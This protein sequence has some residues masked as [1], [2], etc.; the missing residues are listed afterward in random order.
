[1]GTC[2]AVLL[3]LG[4]AGN[5]SGPLAGAAVG[6]LAL[7]SF[8]WLDAS[9]WILS[10]PLFL[11]WTFLA[12]WAADRAI[13]PVRSRG[14]GPGALG[15]SGR[16][17]GPPPEREANGVAVRPVWLLVATIATGL[18]C[19]TRAAG[20]PLALALLAALL[21]GRRFR[22]VSAIAAGLAIPAVLWWIHARGGG[23]AGAYGS[24]L[25]MV[26]PYEPELGT[27]GWLD[28][29]VRA[30]G[31]LR[32][33]VWGVLPGEWWPVQE[34]STAALLGTVLAATAAGG[35]VLRIR[36][37]GVETAELFAPL[38]L[39]MILVW[40][41][42]WSGERFILPLYPLALLYAGVALQW[43]GR[44]LGAG[45]AIAVPALGFVALALPALPGW[46]GLAQDAG[47]CRRTVAVAGD[48][49]RCHTDGIREFREAAEWSRVN[50]PPGAV[51]LNRKPRIFYVLGG[52]PG[53]VFPFTQ[54]PGALLAE[55]D[56]L[57]A[58][59]LLLDHVDAVSPYYLLAVVRASPLAFCYLAGWG[60]EGG[61]VGTDLLGILPPQ[62]RR[63]GGDLSAVQRCPPG[64]RV[65][66]P[67]SVGPDG[68]RIPLLAG[69]G[70]NQPPESP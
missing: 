16:A 70:A 6:L 23:G 55:A 28:L 1:V 18:A 60:G 26:N 50:L 61:D 47:A 7:L 25:W 5:R 54:D 4:W 59:Y 53:R 10:E 42:V 30:W 9:R 20:A 32:L 15:G 52:L 12:L 24:E 39:S 2:V 31:N 48:V 46:L 69:R 17:P 63:E 22:W 13:P 49:F 33:Y 45:A 43:A 35:W 51:V 11:A 3:V 29:P 21:F 66:P 19:M 67:R 58:R 65:D 36:S 8:G 56:A 57:G 68:R 64:Y 44:G 40:P 41:E 37:H 34:G 14:A 62:E 38:Y 27:I